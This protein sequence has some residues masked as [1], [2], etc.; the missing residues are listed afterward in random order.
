MSK[1]KSRILTS[2][3]EIR[4]ISDPYRME[5]LTKLT[6]N[7]VPATSKE[8]A[9]LMGEP[10]SKINYHMKVLEQ[11]KFI[12][13]D[14]TENIN[15]IIAKYYKKIVGEITIETESAPEESGK[16]KAVYDMVKSTFNKARDNYIKGLSDSLDKEGLERAQDMDS[17]RSMS[18]YLTPAELAE[19]HE[20]FDKFGKNQEEGRNLYSMFVASIK[21]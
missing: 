7:K 8:I 19:L 3:K 5:I 1:P 12:E 14:H 6:L 9:T 4:A 11:Y 2:I 17:L 20:L 21:S 15:G 18:I 13:L 10:P 16:N